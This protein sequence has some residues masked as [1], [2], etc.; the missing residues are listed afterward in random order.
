[1]ANPGERFSG[2]II[3]S[4]PACLASGAS[5]LNEKVKELWALGLELGDKQ[6]RREWLSGAPSATS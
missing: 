5:T 2:P 4:P 3:A 1:M 6:W